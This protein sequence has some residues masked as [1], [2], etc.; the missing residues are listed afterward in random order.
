MMVHDLDSRR[1]YVLLVGGIVLLIV[2]EVSRCTGKVKGRWGSVTY[3]DKEPGKFW[4]SVIFGYLIGILF[5]GLALALSA[6]W[7]N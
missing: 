4:F 2:S 1:P 6:G 3:K 5:V 7:F